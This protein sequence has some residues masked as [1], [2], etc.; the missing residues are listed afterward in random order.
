MILRLVFERFTLNMSPRGFHP[1]AEYD[2]CDHFEDHWL[3]RLHKLVRA[4]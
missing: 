3:P 2:V 4:V 1:G